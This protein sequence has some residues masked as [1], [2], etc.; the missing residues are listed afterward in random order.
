MGSKVTYQGDLVT[1]GPSWN[2]WHDCPVMDIIS[3]P[4]IGYGFTDDFT[5]WATPALT[6][7]SVIERA[8][9]HVFGGATGT[10]L[11]DEALGGGL[12]I[13]TSASNEASVIT[14][15]PCY[16]ITSL[17]GALWFEA[18]VKTSTITA[19]ELGLFVGLMDT[20]TVTATIPLGAT[21]TL[22]SINLVGFHKPETNTTAFDTSYRADGVTAVEVNSDVG[23]LVVDTYIKLGM[24]FTPSDAGAA[25]L[26]FYIDNVEQ[27]TKKTIPNATGTDFP[28]DVNMGPVLAVQGVIADDESMTVDW[29]RCYQLRV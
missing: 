8:G 26:R 4:G 5:Q 12:A 15:T 29:V 2:I 7:T 24:K 14:K 20:T 3:D 25:T 9:W 27:A 28:S 11:P 13:L 6:W 21:S 22:G 10:F 17:G 1:N 18:R 23:T 16:N 19:S